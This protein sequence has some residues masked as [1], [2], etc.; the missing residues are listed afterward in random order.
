VERG[1]GIG[2]GKGTGRGA[3]L[4]LSERTLHESER[5][6]TV[7]RIA[8]SGDPDRALSALF[9][10][11]NI[12]ADVLALYAFN[13]E[14]ARIAEQ[15]T[16]PELGAIR[17]Q[18]W[19]EALACAR[20]GGSTGHPVAD[21]MGDLQRRRALAPDRIERL[22]DARNFDI[23]GRIMPDWNALETY[24]HDTAGA[25][26][27]LAASCAG[28]SRALLEPAASHAG[29][30]YGLTGLMRALPVHAARGRIYL[31]ADELRR[32]GTSP[33]AVLAG[34][35]EPGL[36]VLLADLRHKA[37]DAL[38]QARGHIAKLDRRGQAAFL[39]LGLVD[40]YLAALKASGRDPLRE[41][42]NINPLYRLWR[43]ARWRP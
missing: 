24:L 40:P 30:A 37:T 41:I 4:T 42:A 18:W 7:R 10:P 21:A 6:D 34:R 23:A 27:A 33:E 35:T 5:G 13:V 9:A 43:M 17:L 36:L 26:F 31:P 12:R 20:S 1:T 3:H 14:L 15:V 39:P 29:L 11:R 28:V 22:I 16:E 32:H 25:L 8:R 38:D 2:Q 19:R